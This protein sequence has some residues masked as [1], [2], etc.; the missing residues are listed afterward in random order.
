MGRLM[1][2][3]AAILVV[4]ACAALTTCSGV[5]VDALTQ[6]IA[7]E[8]PVPPTAGNS[9]LLTVEFVGAV[10]VEISWEAATDNLTG[11]ELLEYRVFHATE[12]L[13]DTVD[14][15]V[16]GGTP[17]GDWV[18]NVTSATFDGLEQD[19]QYSINVLVRDIAG[20]LSAYNSVT[21]T[22]L[23]DSLAPEPG[24]SGALSV[25]GSSVTSVTF[26]WIKATDNI[27]R[28]ETLQYLVMASLTDNISTLT[29]AKTNGIPVGTWTAD[30]DSV[31]VDNLDPDTT[32]Y[33]NV[34]VRDAVP[35]EA[36][37]NGTSADTQ[38]D[39]TDP[40]PGGSGILVASDEAQESLTLSWT[41]ASDDATDE[42]QIEYRVYWSLL[43]NIDTYNDAE[44]LGNGTAVGAWAIDIGGL[45]VSGL[46]ED[47]T[48][49]LNV[50]ARDE[51]GNIGAYTT[52]AADT[53]RYSRVY[54]SGTS[55]V[56][57][58]SRALLS[59]SSNE[60]VTTATGQ[61]WDIAVDVANRLVYFA[62]YVGTGS[63]VKVVDVSDLYDATPAVETVMHS[64][65]FP[66]GLALDTITGYLYITDI[67]DDAI[68]RVPL[69]TRNE[70]ASTT[71]Y[72]ILGSAGLDLPYGIA[73]DPAGGKIY[74]TE[75]G[76]TPRV[77]SANL[78]GT[79]VANNIH[80]VVAPVAP[81]GIA[82]DS[83]YFYWAD[84]TSDTIMRASKSNPN[85]A[86][87][88]A[89]LINAGLSVAE[90]IEVDD[91]AGI[92]YWA[93]GTNGAIYAAPN[94]LGTPGDASSYQILASGAAIGIGLSLE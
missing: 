77:S 74:W 75:Q 9:G 28:Q 91:T 21:A 76:A 50:F 79:G 30:I 86:G 82:V 84:Q 39:T 18:A 20:N 71:S 6:K 60:Q 22:T 61:T 36:A 45:A 24:A 93:D 89:I 42:E 68:Y 10:D 88:W 87:Q 44:T 72:G 27:S 31:T 83:S 63:F 37:Y 73:V 4:A 67:L 26:S 47:S 64:L 62:E 54:H 7:R 15:V 57:H 49:Y 70:D 59:G 12:G 65:N 56:Y 29:D 1:R 80:S 53:T 2:I 46:T 14:Q 35:L 69:S 19:T 43:D 52:L 55:G 66:V 16:A 5:L 13:L 40:V 58:V 25:S 85:G 3:A 81:S 32:Y 8:E 78:D 33:F 51:A 34:L 38:P 92:M 48:H 23:V 17:V 90:F 11:S 41:R 94:N